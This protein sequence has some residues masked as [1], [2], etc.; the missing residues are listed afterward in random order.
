MRKLL[1]SLLQAMGF[2]S[3]EEAEKKYPFIINEGI[4][5]FLNRLARNFDEAI[6]P[7][8]SELA[9]WRQVYAGEIDDEYVQESS[10]AI[11]WYTNHI[12]MLHRFSMDRVTL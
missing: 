10:S 2:S 11:V 8:K 5:N 1:E 12:E 4:E 6:M 3:V 9:Y 7:L